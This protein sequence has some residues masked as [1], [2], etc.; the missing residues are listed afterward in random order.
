MRRNWDA[1]WLVSRREFIDQFRD[2]R[3]VVPMLLLISVF[4]FIADD[5]T[6][7]AI[8][9]MNRFGGDLILDNLIP[10]VILVIGFFPLSFT[11][12]VALE[13]FVG[14]KERGTIEPLLSSPLE[15]KQLYLGKLLV[16]IIT[17]LVFSFLSIVIYLILVS[18]RNV[19]FPSAY[20]LSLIF[21]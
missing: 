4:P 9:F 6:R 10:F 7:Q 3:I 14:E 19:E 17:P 18:R 8:N 13:S 20:M 1:I 12:V 2:W 15:D 16:G 21:I 11:L 5:T